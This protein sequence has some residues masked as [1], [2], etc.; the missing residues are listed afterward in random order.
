MENRCYRSIKPTKYK[1]AG[2][3]WPSVP[4]Y[5]NLTMV[6]ACSKVDS[7]DLDS[8]KSNFYISSC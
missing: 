7:G 6:L 2:Y 5:D 4:G 8:V 1:E 3:T